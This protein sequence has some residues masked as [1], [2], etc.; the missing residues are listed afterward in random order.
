MIYMINDYSEGYKI[1]TR[2]Q[3]LY[4]CGYFIVAVKELLG[5]HSCKVVLNCENN[6]VAW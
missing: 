6:I 2:L 4:L 5:L 1:S 3:H